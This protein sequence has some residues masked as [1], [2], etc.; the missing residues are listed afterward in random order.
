M[1]ESF[2]QP[3][4]AWAGGALTTVTQG[5][6]WLAEALGGISQWILNNQEL[7]L[8]IATVAGLVAAQWAL[9][10]G[11]ALVWNAVMP[12]ATAAAKLFGEGLGFLTSKT[13][14]WSIAIGALIAVIVLLVTHW[15]E[16]K[17]VAI[18]VWQ[19]IQEAWGQVCG[20][21]RTAVID[22]LAAAWEGFKNTFVSLW[23]GMKEGAK[24]CVNGILGFFNG[25]IRGVV[26][27]VNGIVRLINK[28]NW[29]IPDWPIFGEYGGKS[30]GFHIQELSAPQI[31]ML[32]RGA[33]L[34]ANRPFLALV[35]D[36]RRGTNVEA[37][38]E[39]IQAAVAAVMEETAGANMAG[40][41]AVVG[42]LKE[43]LEAV[44][45]IH[46]GDE[47]VARAVARYNAKMAVVKGGGLI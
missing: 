29:D 20:W 9:I 45:G 30:F 19:S 27:G 23:E 24:G 12:L 43:I 18:A 38:L 10:N 31:P 14:L 32:A 15:D 34:P 16:V 2:L 4:T 35:G 26:D 8:A 36:Q 41:E 37:P 7:V 33:V 46:I 28:L 6:S 39:T 22:P 42:V 47:E 21:F 1:W 3:L 40:F 17:A 5:L 13:G 25:M 44:C 11:A